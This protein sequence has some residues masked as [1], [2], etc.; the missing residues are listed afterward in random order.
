[1]KYQI[2]KSVKTLRASIANGWH[3]SPGAGCLP[4]NQKSP[5]DSREQNTG[6]LKPNQVVTT[7]GSGTEDNFLDPV[8]GGGRSSQRWTVRAVKTIFE[9]LR[10]I[11]G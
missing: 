6:G 4:K 3:L 5:G 1:M 10:S 2:F 7:V 11:Y 9:S 8:P